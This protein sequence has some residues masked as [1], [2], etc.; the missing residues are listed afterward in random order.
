MPCLSH[1]ID[2]Y[3][4][5]ME[6]TVHFKNLLYRSKLIVL[7][8]VVYIYIGSIGILGPGPVGGNDTNCNY[9]CPQNLISSKP[10]QYYNSG[11]GVR[12][13]SKQQLPLTPRKG[14]N[15]IPVPV[16]MTVLYT[17]L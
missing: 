17:Y 1:L 5:A 10:D 13:D 4:A 12:M 2:F 9:Y 6:I 7:L 8:F 11:A 14:M 15:V 16:P 3:N